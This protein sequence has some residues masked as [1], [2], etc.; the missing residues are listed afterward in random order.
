[1]KL[2]ELM[3]HLRASPPRE[4]QQRQTF[5]SDHLQ[6]C[7]HAFVRCDMVKK[8]LQALY[9]GPY[10]IISRTPKHFT[11]KV[12][13]RTEVISLDRLKPA[14]LD[15]PISSSD[16][17]PFPNPQTAETIIPP[18]DKTSS[19]YKTTTHSGRRVRWPKHLK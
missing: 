16:C 15:S 13:G 17:L 7:T 14:F 18:T 6:T 11:L 9:D 1:M 3:K 5:V 12:K 19:D 8:P 2:K 10:E 4:Q